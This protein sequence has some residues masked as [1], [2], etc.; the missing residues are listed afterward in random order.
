MVKED[1]FISVAG[2]TNEIDRQSLSDYL[3][4]NYISLIATAISDGYKN[5]KLQ[6]EINQSFLKAK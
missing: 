4:M 5:H 3:T 2:K 1:C 6:F